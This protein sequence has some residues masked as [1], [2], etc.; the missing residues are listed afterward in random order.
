MRIIAY[1]KSH[2]K[3]KYIAEVKG[4]PYKMSREYN[5]QEHDPDD[6][7]HLAEAITPYSY[8]KEN[9]F[10]EEDIYLYRGVLNFYAGEYTKACKDFQMS[11]VKKDENKDEN[12][13]SDTESETSN[14]TDLSDVGLCSLNVHECKYNQAL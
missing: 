10:S 11:M 9:I 6:Y 14:Q 7:K 13:N 2:E 1:L 3:D 5:E 12:E 8:Y 4:E